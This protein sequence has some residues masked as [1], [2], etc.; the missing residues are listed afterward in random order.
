MLA[1]KVPKLR[2][3]QYN[4][5]LELA[6]LEYSLRKPKLRVTPKTETSIARITEDPR[7]RLK[8]E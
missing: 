3:A 7:K 1:T 2:A 6:L 5:P 4:K 8:E